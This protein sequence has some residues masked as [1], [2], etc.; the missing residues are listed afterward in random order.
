MGFQL[1]YFTK[2]LHWQETHVSTP[3]DRTRTHKLTLAVLYLNSWNFS[4][5]TS[6]VRMLLSERVI[7]EWREQREE[8]NADWVNCVTFISLTLRAVE[9]R[10]FKMKISYLHQNTGRH[11]PGHVTGRDA[12]VNTPACA[13]AE[14]AHSQGRHMECQDVCNIAS[15]T[16]H[17][18]PLQ[19]CEAW[20]RG[21]VC[22]SSTPHVTCFLDQWRG[23]IRN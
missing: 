11:D 8:S 2:G 20:K 12:D 21:S 5:G 18:A 6:N 9:M 15:I 14:A 7:C 16:H 1:V 10:T 17:N 4:S 3:P 19:I 13:N 23:G 22:H